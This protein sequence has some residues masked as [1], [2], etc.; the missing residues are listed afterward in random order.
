M[1]LLSKATGA[2]QCAEISYFKPVTLLGSSGRR[3]RIFK[4][5]VRLFLYCIIKY[6]FVLSKKALI[7]QISLKENYRYNYFRVCHQITFETINK[8]GA[9]F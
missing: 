1:D 8:H 4:L 2:L 5:P 3:P 7:L 6:I 9:D